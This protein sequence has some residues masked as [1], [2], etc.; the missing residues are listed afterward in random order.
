V[1]TAF[2]VSVPSS[3][4]PNASYFYLVTAKHCI[5]NAKS[6]GPLSVRVNTKEGKAQIIRLDPDWLYAEDERTDVAVLPLMP[7]MD[8]C[9]YKALSVSVF[10]TQEF[11]EQKGVGIGDDLAVIGLF[12][13]REGTQRNQPIARTGI[14][15][16][17]ADERLQDHKSGEWYRAYLAEVRPIGGL[18]GSPVFVFLWPG[19]VYKNT[20]D[21]IGCSFGLLGMIR[22]HWDYKRFES[23]VDYTDEELRDVNMGIAI[24]T[25]AEDILGVIN[26]EELVKQRRQSDKRILSQRA[27]TEDSAFSI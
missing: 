6:E 11:I 12:T 22:G 10:A 16:S 3:N 21:L 5:E 15:A 14:I 9:S 1:G 19:R 24:V 26:G 4:V 13:M 2:F 20:L 8:H 25:P 18:S 7:P 27:P 17:M 23:L